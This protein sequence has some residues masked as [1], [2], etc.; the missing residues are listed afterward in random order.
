MAQ[1][2]LVVLRNKETG[3]AIYTRKNKKGV[4]RKLELK[5]FS[6]KLKKRVTFKEAKK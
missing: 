6:K 4:Q 2:Q 5:K 3:E 1:E